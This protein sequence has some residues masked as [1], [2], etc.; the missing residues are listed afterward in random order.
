MVIYHTAPVRC[1][2]LL[3]EQMAG[4]FSNAYH[5]RMP[6][7]ARNVTDHRFGMLNNVI[8]YNYAMTEVPRKSLPSNGF[9]H[10]V[11]DNGIDFV[12]QSQLRD[13]D[14]LY[15]VFDGKLIRKHK[16]DFVF[17]ILSHP[18]R[19]IYDLFHYLSFVNRTSSEEER[20][21]EGVAHF[22]AIVEAG[23]SQFVDKFLA[24]DRDIVVGGKSF[25]LIEDVFRYN[26]EVEYDFVG[27]E[28]RID[29]AVIA[30]S[31]QLD[32]AISTSEKL[33]S[34]HSSIASESR[35]RYEELC[36]SLGPEVAKYE[37]VAL[38]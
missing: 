25:Y 10:N 30:L 35:Y 36:S 33:L 14:F 24:G 34:R 1:F 11:L 22:D 16:G 21:T 17:T 29:E 32:I 37:A 26:L 2:P 4:Q 38:T 18:V 20:Y 8:A 12:D 9:P 15:G 3:V 13:I 28:T 6:I 7:M 27:T 5:F 31:N 23:I 19:H